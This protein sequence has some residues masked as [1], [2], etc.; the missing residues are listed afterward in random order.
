MLCFT[1]L[2]AKALVCDD[3]ALVMSANLQKHGLDEGFELGVRLTGGDSEALLAVLRVWS[4]QA[5]WRLEIPATLGNVSGEIVPLTPAA[6][7]KKPEPT[8][9]IKTTDTVTLD[10]VTAKSADRL[11]EAKLS[12]ANLRQEAEKRGL[13]WVHEVVLRYSLRAPRVPASAKLEDRTKGP[14]ENRADAPAGPRVYRLSDG[15]KAVGVGTPADAKA[16]RVMAESLG[17]KTI[18][19]EGGKS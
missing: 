3:Q 6:I 1:W 12:E 8:I 11:D 14:K 19:A 18:L 15:S 9:R 17:I 2:H 4:D 16:A 13:T 7:P 10:A 5:P